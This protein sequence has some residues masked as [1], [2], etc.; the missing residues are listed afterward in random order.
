MQNLRSNA[1]NQ[2]KEYIQTELMIEF[3][4]RLSL[5]KLFLREEAE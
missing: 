3:G 2:R 4:Y 1:I 5:S